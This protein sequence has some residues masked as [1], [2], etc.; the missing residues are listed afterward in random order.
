MVREEEG[1][2]G[3]KDRAGADQEV[4]VWVQDAG[5]K[6]PEEKQTGSK[7]DE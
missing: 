4:E 2:H 3:C 7:F 6:P 5:V 1:F